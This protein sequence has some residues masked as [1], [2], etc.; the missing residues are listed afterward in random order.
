MRCAR[1]CVITLALGLSIMTS[2]KCGHGYVYLAHYNQYGSAQYYEYGYGIG[3]FPYASNYHL[4]ITQGDS[5]RVGIMW[6][7]GSG[8]ALGAIV[9]HDEAPVEVT[10]SSFFVSMG[11]HYDMT[12][13]N[14]VLT[15]Y[16]TLDIQVEAQTF[17]SIV[18]M[19]PGSNPR[20][21]LSCA[22]G[23]LS[24][25]VAEC[26]AGGELDLLNA[27]GVAVRRWR[28]ARVENDVNL[29]I[30]D[31]SSGSYVLSMRGIRGTASVRFFKP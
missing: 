30:A 10:S 18:A 17:V 24:V 14:Y 29:D 20:L 8:C 2:A 1:T 22:G 31:L 15:E 25:R 3:P 12:F 21:L 5:V 13:Y 6:T 11:G 27:L 9:T 7:G 23:S 16:Y 26:Y 4:T 19:Q 28:I